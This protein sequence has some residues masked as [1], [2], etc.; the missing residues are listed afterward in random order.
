[1]E[2]KIGP[3]GLGPVKTSEKVLEEYSNKGLTA[4]EIPFTYGAY[5]KKK[6]DA[7][8]IGKKA[9]E[10]GIQLSIHAPYWINLNSNEEEKVQ[11]SKE[12]ILRSLEVGTWLQA[13]KVVFHPG[14]Y[15]G[16]GYD[17]TYENISKSIKEIIKEASKKGFTPV[18]APETTGKVNVFGSIEEISRLVEDTGCGFCVDFAHILAREKNYSFDKV[19]NAFKKS[20]DFHIHFSGI[21]YAEKGE[22]RHIPT[23]NKDI[24]EL[25]SNLEKNSKGKIFTIISE[26]PNPFEDSLK[27]K[28]EVSRRT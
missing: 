20:G 16:R 6:E 3:S 4:C 26:A 2:I 27:I 9:K 10:L 13:T 17:D 11:K 8:R 24:L 15:A 23:E 12:R 19:F 28:K 1:M 5:I 22:K 21:E 7:E 14:Y 18:L 25:L